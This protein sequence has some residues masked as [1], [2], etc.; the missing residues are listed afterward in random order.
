MPTRF[1]SPSSLASSS[2]CAADV[3]QFQQHIS[4]DQAVP[5]IYEYVGGTSREAFESSAF[6]PEDEASHPWFPQPWRSARINLHLV[7]TNDDVFEET[8]TL[9]APLWQCEYHLDGVLYNRLPMVITIYPASTVQPWH[10]GQDLCRVSF[11]LSLSMLSSLLR[12]LISL[13]NAMRLLIA[14]KEAA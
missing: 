9:I 2:S 5:P 7:V 11:N 6:R 1:F 4:N 14:V 10:S 8:T 12:F 13:P 3:C